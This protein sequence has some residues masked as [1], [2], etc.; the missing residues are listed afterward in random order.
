MKYDLSQ[1]LDRN[2]YETRSRLMLERR[3]FVEFGE[4]V[5]R[6]LSQNNYQHLL[7]G[8]VALETGEPFDY[9]K[10]QYFKRMVNAPYFVVEKRDPYLGDTEVLR[11]SRDLTKEEMSIA[12]DRWKRWG[13]QEGFY[14]P[15]P[16]DKE[17]LRRIQIEMGRNEKYL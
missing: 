4:I 11:S 6:T 10:E 7:I 2:R 8:V 17:L 5:S 1:D 3:A 12:I 14:M 15:E 13:N 16:G 9:V